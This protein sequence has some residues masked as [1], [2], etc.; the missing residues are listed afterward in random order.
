MRAWIAAPFFGIALCACTSDQKTPDELVLLDESMSLS[1]APS[2]HIATREVAVDSDSIIV[3]S[4]EEELA[5]VHV[6]L[7]RVGSGAEPAVQVENNL[8]GAG[9]E[10]ATLSAAGSSCIR[11]TIEGRPDAAVPGHVRLRVTR[12]RVRDRGDRPYAVR[13]AGYE[14]WS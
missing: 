1:R 9:T 7:E 4:V 14:A 8:G 6:R 3:A 10:I 11:I 12:F 13:L 2:A 5:D